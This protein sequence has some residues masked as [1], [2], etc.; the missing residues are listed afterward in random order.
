MSEEELTARQA[1]SASL[2]E[3]VVRE[4]GYKEGTFCVKLSGLQ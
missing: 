1:S 4:V 2:H 3:R